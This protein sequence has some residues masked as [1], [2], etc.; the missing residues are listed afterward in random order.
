[1]KSRR[2]VVPSV[3]KR[4]CV[5]RVKKTEFRNRW[6]RWSRLV[7]VVMLVAQSS[8]D[9]V[10]EGGSSRTKSR[11]SRRK[12]KK[13]RKSKS[14]KSKKSKRRKQRKQKPHQRARHITIP[15]HLLHKAQRQSSRRL[16]NRVPARVQE[17]R[18]HS[19]ECTALPCYHSHHHHSNTTRYEL[20]LLLPQAQKGVHDQISKENVDVLD[21]SR[22]QTRGENTCGSLQKVLQCS[23][24]G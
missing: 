16:P 8:D 12:S 6:R 18:S 22:M 21:R 11:K 7:G 23:V 17:T 3:R 24:S 2:D 19:R 4:P 10:E 5:F 15:K 20:Q 13:S 1:M 9:A 14:R